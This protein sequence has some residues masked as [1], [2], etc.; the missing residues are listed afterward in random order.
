MKAR[1]SPS[2]RP[3][4]EGSRLCGQVAVAALSGSTL[5]EAIHAVGHRH[6]SKTRELVHAL[7]TLGLEP[8]AS[9]CRKMTRPD[10]GLAQV[11][12]P[13]YSGWHWIAV[14]GAYAYDGNERG[15]IAFSLYE[16]AAAKQYKRG[17]R[18][19]SYLPVRRP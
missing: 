19:T 9:R 6:G 15:P 12:L 14:D 3:Q 18:I 11:H 13:G 4:P 5:E 2:W 8:L 7:L 16:T 10:F 17:A 1:R